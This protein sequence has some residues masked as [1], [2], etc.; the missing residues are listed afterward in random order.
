MIYKIYYILHRLLF[1][2]GFQKRLSIIVPVNI[3]ASLALFTAAAIVLMFKL[4]NLNMEFVISQRFFYLILLSFTAI[5][6]VFFLIKGQNY[7]KAESGE[8]I[9][10]KHTILLIMAYSLIT[11]VIPILVFIKFKVGMYW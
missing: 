4:L 7:I 5:S 6:L 10:D 2:A 8:V 1:D 3:G 11:V 9:L